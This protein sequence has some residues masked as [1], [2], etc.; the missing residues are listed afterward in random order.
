VL[1]AFFSRILEHDVAVSAADRAAEGRPPAVAGVEP[2]ADRDEPPAG[3]A[4]QPGAAHDGAQLGKARVS[5]GRRP[6]HD[7][8]LLQVLLACGSVPLLHPVDDG[9]TPRAAA[10]L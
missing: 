9:G 6:D 4:D 10:I 7:G 8:T 3:P 5:V 1:Q 2:A